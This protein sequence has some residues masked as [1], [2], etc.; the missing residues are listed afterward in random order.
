[1]TREALIARYCPEMATNAEREGALIERLLEVE[2]DAE[3]YL[4]ALVRISTLEAHS[5]GSFPVMTGEL[6]E[7]ARTAIYQARRKP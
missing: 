4:R 2:A 1:M 3:L 7:I 5:E 6:R